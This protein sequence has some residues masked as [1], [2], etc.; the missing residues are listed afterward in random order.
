MDILIYFIGFFIVLLGCYLWNVIINRSD[1]PSW[2]KE[3]HTIPFSGALLVSIFSWFT[4]MLVLI[5]VI[6][7]L[8]TY[9]LLES[10]IS[11]RVDVFFSGKKRGNDDNDI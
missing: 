7:G 9:A 2:D 4:V 11:K 1:M 6:A 10:K 5:F 8:L 3:G